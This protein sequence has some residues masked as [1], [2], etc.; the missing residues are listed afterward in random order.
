MLELY[1]KVNTKK[2]KWKK[3]YK[4][5]LMGLLKDIKL[6]LSNAEIVDPKKM[7]YPS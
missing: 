6:K 1:S 4:Y 3:Y 7:I 2:V 5:G